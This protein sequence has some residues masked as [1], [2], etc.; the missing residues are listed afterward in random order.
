MSRKLRAGLVTLA[1][2]VGM[3]LTYVYASR[4]PG[5]FHAE[6]RRRRRSAALPHVPAD[7]VTERDVDRLPEPVA[8]YVRR[9]GAV[10]RP[11]V[12][13]LDLRWHGRIRSSPDARWMTFTG[14]Q[15]STFGVQ[16]LRLFHLQARMFGVPVDVFHVFDESGA[17]MRVKAL[18]L[19][20]MV[21]AAG[22]DMNRSETVT[23]LNDLCVLAPAALLDTSI[24][25][26]P[27][28]DRRVR[29]GYPLRGVT[30]AAE[31]VFDQDGDLVDFVS[32]DRL[33][34]SADGRSF[35][36]Q[37]WSTPVGGYRRFGP[38]RIAARS[39]AQWHAPH[40]EGTFAYIELTIDDV[41]YDEDLA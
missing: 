13:H 29:A 34:A 4:G 23:M 37:R 1:G 15:F 18:S 10:G 30:V 31:L 3:A 5:S 41:R 7:P 12:T 28:G 11:H 32:D 17:T 20:P 14:E 22:R 8:T 25:W 6:Y 26:H 9:S 24:T 2:L 19:I 16:P 33:R 35:T 39:A 38:W 21:S 27:L 36:R 40:P